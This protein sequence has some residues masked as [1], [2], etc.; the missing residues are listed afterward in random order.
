[1]AVITVASPSGF[2]TIA[3]H[4]NVFATLVEVAAF[5]AKGLAPIVGA[6]VGATVGGRVVGVELF[7]P[8]GEGVIVMVGVG[9][10]VFVGVM[11]A[12][13]V[14]VCNAAAAVAVFALIWASAT[15]VPVCCA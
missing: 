10:C 15:T 6:I 5:S 1:M 7:V 11:V 14:L 4:G 12:G 2:T 3:E 13:V 9:N 8:I